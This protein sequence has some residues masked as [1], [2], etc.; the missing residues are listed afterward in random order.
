MTEEPV[1]EYVRGQGWVTTS[2]NNTII[3]NGY[4]ITVYNRPPV[5][6]N[7]E[8]YLVFHRRDPVWVINEQLDIPKFLDHI[9]TIRHMTP[10]FYPMC[11][12]RTITVN[13]IELIQTITF[14]KDGYF[15]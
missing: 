6:G 10:D 12:E 4:T 5:P 8:R 2:T 3:L 7:R 9:T 13:D 15:W 1:Y 11:H 14:F